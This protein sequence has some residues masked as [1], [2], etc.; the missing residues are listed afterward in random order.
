MAAL[1][2]NRNGATTIAIR[3]AVDIQ[4]KQKLPGVDIMVGTIGALK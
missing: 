4:E 3:V 2:K 1:V